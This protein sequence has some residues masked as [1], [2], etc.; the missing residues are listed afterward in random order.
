MSPVTFLSLLSSPFLPLLSPPSL[1][2]SSFLLSLFSFLLLFSSL[3]FYL[4]VRFHE[5]KTTCQ[6]SDAPNLSWQKYALSHTAEH[7]DTAE[8]PS[9]QTK[10]LRRSQCWIKDAY[11]PPSSRILSDIYA[12]STTLDLINFYELIHTFFSEKINMRRARLATSFYEIR[13][14]TVNFL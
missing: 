12:A 11:V 5:I 13:F 9:L 6:V 7:P 4:C 10:L 3:S 8:V 14:H 1:R 2:F